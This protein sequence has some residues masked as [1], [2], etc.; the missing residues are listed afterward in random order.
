MYEVYALHWSSAY[1][2]SLFQIDTRANK[3]ENLIRII[4]LWKKLNDFH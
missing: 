1:Y 4:H 2:R 3:V